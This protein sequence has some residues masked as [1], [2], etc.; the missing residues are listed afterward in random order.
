[1]QIRASRPRRLVVLGSTGTIGEQTLELARRNPDRVAVVGL[2]AGSNASRLAR[3]AAEFT[4][5]AV[6][7]GNAGALP[8]LE[9]Q[10]GA[11]GGAELLAGEEGLCR[12]AAWPGAE[13]VVNAVVGAAGLRPTLAALETGGRLGLAN[14]ESLVMAGPLVRAA[15]ARGGSEIIP[16]DSEH[17]ALWQLLQGRDPGEVHRLLLTASGGPFRT[18][19]SEQLARV[20][21]EQALR[22]PTWTM[23]RRITIDSATLFNKG[24]ELIEA[25]WLFDL[26]LERIEA[27]V[28]PQAVVHGLVELIDGSTLAQLSRPD[29]RLP[30]QLALSL[31]IRWPAADVRWHWGSGTALCFEPVDE[32]RFPCLGIARAAGEAEGIAPAVVNAADEILV[33]AFL[34]GRISFPAIAEGLAAVLQQHDPVPDP[35]LVDI[36]AADAWARRAVGEWL[37]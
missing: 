10:R 35:S 13:I 9:R 21:P 33:G 20:T 8:E 36:L 11:T 30:I 23:G 7:V 5:E 26:P 29:M 31:P 22:H 34:D 37:P 16:I 14:K 18:F 19:T 25:R 17:S 27:V 32:E 15:A 3:Q 6:A 28:H 12:L 1:L 24:M 4:P 2:A